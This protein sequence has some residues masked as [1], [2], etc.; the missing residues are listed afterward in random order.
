ML[1]SAIVELSM[2]C[3]VPNEPPSTPHSTQ[4]KFELDKAV[5]TDKGEPAHA[6]CFCCRYSLSQIL[7]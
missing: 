3:A 5:R 4:G 1:F 7:K 2:P 6:K